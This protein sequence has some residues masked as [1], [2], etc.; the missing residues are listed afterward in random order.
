MYRNNN[1]FCKLRKRIEELESQV[2]QNYSEDSNLAGKVQQIENE[3][4][5][6][7]TNDS[8]L[9]D[10]VDAISEIET[11][12]INNLFSQQNSSAENI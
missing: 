6:N 3:L 10:R 2:I 12:D 4:D 1:G 8:E 7:T 9:K 5:E 11:E